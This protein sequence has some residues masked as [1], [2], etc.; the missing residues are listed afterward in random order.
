MHLGWFEVVAAIKTKHMAAAVSIEECETELQGA[1]E[2][3][4]VTPHSP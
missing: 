4:R 2:I 1:S 3:T